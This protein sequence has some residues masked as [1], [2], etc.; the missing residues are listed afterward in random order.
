MN[1]SK[2]LIAAGAILLAATFANA[3]YT[4]PTDGKLD[5]EIKIDAAAYMDVI[6]VNASNN[7]WAWTPAATPVVGNLKQIG[8]ILVETNLAQFDITLT[9]TNGGYL[10]NAADTLK[11]LVSGKA[12]PIKPILFSCVD[13][14]NVAG[15]SSICAPA[16]LTTSTKTGGKITLGSAAIS[17]ATVS[18]TATGFK[19]AGD[20]K[21]SANG[22]ATGVTTGNSAG[23]GLPYMRIGLYAGMYTNATTPAA[24]AAANLVGDG[25][26]KDTYTIKFVKGY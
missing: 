5:M 8:E 10:L 11:G 9:S 16:S 6:A 2:K 21:A 20:L 22:A 25:T 23:P 14:T 17:L 13:T 12:V 3:A 24:V 18:G 26:Y 15:S 19:L 4:N 1:I 7:A